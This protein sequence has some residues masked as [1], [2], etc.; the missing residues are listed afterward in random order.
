[1]WETEKLFGFGSLS[2]GGLGVWVVALIR[3]GG[4]GGWQ[5]VVAAAVIPSPPI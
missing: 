4:P 3:A 5:A 1:M 2:G